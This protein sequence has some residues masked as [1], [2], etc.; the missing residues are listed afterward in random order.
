VKISVGATHH[1]INE[2]RKRAVEIVLQKQD[3]QALERE[4]PARSSGA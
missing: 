2:D 1:L 3:S 4:D